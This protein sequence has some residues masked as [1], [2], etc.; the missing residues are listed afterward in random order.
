[1]VPSLFNKIK[2]REVIDVS[3]TQRVASIRNIR[4][5][6]IDASNTQRVSK[7]KKYKKL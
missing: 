7:Y 4:T 6:V 5:E 2:K 3:N 1:M